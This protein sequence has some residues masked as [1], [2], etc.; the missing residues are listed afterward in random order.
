MHGLGQ[1]TSTSTKDIYKC[2]FIKERERQKE[3]YKEIRK[4]NEKKQDNSDIGRMRERGRET[5]RQRKR[6]RDRI[7]IN[8]LGQETSTK[9]NHMEKKRYRNRE[10]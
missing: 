6:Q 2:I 9:K 7:L 4:K 5:E 8:R 1:E 3:R 10:N